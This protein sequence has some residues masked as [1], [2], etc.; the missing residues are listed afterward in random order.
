MNAISNDGQ[1]GTAEPLSRDPLAPRGRVSIQVDMTILRQLDMTDLRN[2]RDAV[3]TTS[4]VMAGLCCQPRFSDDNNNYTHAGRIVENILEFLNA[5]EQ[6][7]VNVARAATPVERREV[8][9]R[10]WTILGFE[11][12]MG[13]DLA[14]F[15]VHAAE[16]VRDEANVKP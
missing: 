7:A 10:H 9:A 15:A 2:L 16:A 1:R 8:E 6:A 3:R 4:D 11:A 13:D 14:D 5:Y 12:V